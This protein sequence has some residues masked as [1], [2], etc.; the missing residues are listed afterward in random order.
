MVLL[1]VIGIILIILGFSIAI[2][3]NYILYSISDWLS[4]S[5]MILPNVTSIIPWIGLGII[6]FGLV[7]LIIGM[8]S[9][10]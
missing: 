7:M 6:I 4:I 3:G 10:K 5:Y 8:K 2:L 9:R 1:I